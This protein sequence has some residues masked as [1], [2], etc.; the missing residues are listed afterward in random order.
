MRWCW[1][2]PDASRRCASRSI[3]PIT[4]CSTRSGYSCRARCRDRSISAGYG[5]AFRSA[6]TSGG[7]SRSN[8]SPRPAARFPLGPNGSPYRRGVVD[9]RLSVAV[10]RVTEAGLPLMYVNQVGGQDEL[11]FEGA[12]FVLNADR[13][14]VVQ[15]PAFRE[16]VVT[17][18][19]ERADG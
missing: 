2:K 8:A 5:W 9:Q 6:R 3:C 13:S 18:R 11:V 15:L 4:A 19:W 10:A 1:R 17:T 12:S 14:M 7:R 16:A